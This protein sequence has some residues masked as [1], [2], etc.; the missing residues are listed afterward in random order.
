MLCALL[1]DSSRRPPIY[2]LFH[3]W[4]L[5]GYLYLLPP[6]LACKP[7]PTLA[8]LMAYA[9]VHRERWWQQSVHRSPEKASK[10]PCKERFIN[11]NIIY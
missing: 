7:L 9:S 6:M 1:V 2:W 10:R 5:F 4:R 11:H 8:M 3:S